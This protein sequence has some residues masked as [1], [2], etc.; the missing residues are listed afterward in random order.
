MSGWG[1]RLRGIVFAT[2]IYAV[3]FVMGVVGLPFAAVSRDFA[4]GWMRLYTRIVFAL[5]RALA[6]VRVEL[7]GPVPQEPVIVA[8]K[9]QSMLD[10]LLLYSVLPR[11]KF[12]IKRSLLWVPVFGLYTWRIGGIFIDRQARG[13]GNR[14]LKG[15]AAQTGERGQ[16]VLYPQATRVPLGEKRPYRRGAAMLAREFGLPLIP[17]ATN[18]G[19]F[20]SREG[21]LSGPGTAVIEFLPEVARG[22]DDDATMRRVE[23]AVE[24]AS[25]RLSEEAAAALGLPLPEPRSAPRSAPGRTG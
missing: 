8:A 5:M 14:V 20:W 3:M 4:Y 9:H 11:A 25:D 22:P 15:M 17:A 24:T 21:R 19:W 1:P 7:R 18:A 13:Q 16:I 23:E 12:V 2:A 10:V 6:G